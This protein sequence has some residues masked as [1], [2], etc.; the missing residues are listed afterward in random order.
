MTSTLPWT[1]YLPAPTSADPVDVGLAPGP[2]GV[3]GVR[4]AGWHLKASSMPAQ[5]KVSFSSFAGNTTTGYY[6]RPYSNTTRV[7]NNGLL[8]TPNTTLL[9]EDHEYQVPVHV[10]RNLNGQI[11]SLQVSV[12]DFSGAA[13]A[14]DGGLYLRLLLDINDH[15]QVYGATPGARTSTSNYYITSGQ[16][17]PQQY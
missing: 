12:T 4:V 15:Y 14:I 11:N 9:E 7:I 16:A 2:A 8:F 10:L 6:S 13:V 3:V 1:L 5:V 17:P